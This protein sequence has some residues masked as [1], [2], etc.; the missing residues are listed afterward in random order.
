MVPGTGAWEEEYTRKGILWS[1]VTHDLPELPVG[2]RVLELGCG[3]GKTLPHMI[4]RGWNVTA[5]DSSQKAVALSRNLVKGSSPA[6]IMVADARHIPVKDTTF[7]AVF[8]I[9]VV[10]HLHEP[11][12]E[13]IVREVTRVLKPGGIVFFCDFSTGDVRFG[14]GH[15][16]EPSTFIRG[17]KIITHYFSRQEVKDLFSGFT[18]TSITLHQWLM[19]VRGKDLVRSEVIGIFSK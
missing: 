1:G 3:N 15:A 10:G 18:C 14:K 8:A 12:R 5:L 19:R 4:Q 9:H 6:E 13:E 7:D 16:S 17:T 11:D 2:S